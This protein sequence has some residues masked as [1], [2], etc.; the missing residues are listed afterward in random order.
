MSQT[1]VEEVPKL[2]NA[3]NA[4]NFNSAEF[5]AAEPPVLSSGELQS[6]AL[7]SIHATPVL[8]Y[9]NAGQNASNNLMMAGMTKFEEEKSAEFESKFD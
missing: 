3:N 4:P 7:Q 9:Q 5:V 8:Q 1:P 2:P 6:S